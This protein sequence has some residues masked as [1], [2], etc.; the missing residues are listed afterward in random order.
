MHTRTQ[1]ACEDTNPARAAVFV[2][3]RDLSHSF[4]YNQ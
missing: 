4:L 3:F 1:V 2:D